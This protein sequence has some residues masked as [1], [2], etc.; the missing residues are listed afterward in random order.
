MSL[1]SSFAC[2]LLQLDW[3]EVA[4][5]ADIAVHMGIAVIIAVVIAL[6]QAQAEGIEASGILRIEQVTMITVPLLM[7]TL[8]PGTVA[9]MAIQPLTTVIATQAAIT[10]VLQHILL[11]IAQQIPQMAKNI[12]V[13]W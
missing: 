1:Q 5:L 8:Q 2:Q 9:R 12:T 10:A 11:T 6:P 7:T 13:A 3:P 4:G